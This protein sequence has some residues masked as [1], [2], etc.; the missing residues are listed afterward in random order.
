MIKPSF[1]REEVAR[2]G[3]AAWERDIARRVCGENL[4]SFVAI[5]VHTGAYEV[6]ADEGWAIRRL[7]DRHPGAQFWLRR[8]GSPIAHSFGPRTEYHA[9]VP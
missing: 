9:P 8:V 4:R 5:D 2:R 6:D 3:E 1:T 7:L